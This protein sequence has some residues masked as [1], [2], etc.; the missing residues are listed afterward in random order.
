MGKRGPKS[1][2]ELSVVAGFGAVRPAPPAHLTAPQ[3]DVWRS[4]VDRMPAEWFTPETRPVLVALCRHVVQADVIAR[5]LE[6][7]AEEWLTSEDGLRRYDRLAA[8]LDREGRA[9]ANLSTRLRLTP[10]SRYRP[11]TAGTA[12]DAAGALKKPWTDDWRTA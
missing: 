2:A 7:M 4:I 8:M 5:Q 6:G 10:Q 3:A 11:K 9:V 12:A 1:Q